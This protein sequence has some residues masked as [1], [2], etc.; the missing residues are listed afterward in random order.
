MPT[1]D[2][3]KVKGPKGDKGEQGIQGI[4]G[5]KGEKGDTGA[6]GANATINGVIALTLAT[7]SGLSGSQ[8]GNTYTLSLS[9]H[10]QAA[11]TIT[12]GTFAGQVAANISGQTPGTS[13]LRNSKLVSADTNPTVNGE[14]CW[15]YK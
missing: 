14:I 6:P 1:F 13:L 12:A 15:T 11:S 4:P 9:A 10:N 8:S 5:E 7:G 3:G 2:L